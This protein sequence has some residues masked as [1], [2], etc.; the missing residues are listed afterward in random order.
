MQVSFLLLPE[1]GRAL[2]FNKKDFGREKERCTTRGKSRSGEEKSYPAAKYFYTARK[3]TH[4]KR[5]DLTDKKGN[6]QATTAIGVTG[7]LSTAPDGKE[8]NGEGQVSVSAGNT[9][10]D[11]ELFGWSGYK[12]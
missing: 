11:R 12:F 5:T 9:G 7:T 6:A 2:F 8:V 4:R 1:Y 10:A 3:K